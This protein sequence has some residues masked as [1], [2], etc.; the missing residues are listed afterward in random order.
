MTRLGVHTI[1]HLLPSPLSVSHHMISL[2]VQSK[3]QTGIRIQN[4]AAI[5]TATASGAVSTGTDYITGGTPL[6]ATDV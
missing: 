6:R 1:S 3:I 5:A 2:S 4:T